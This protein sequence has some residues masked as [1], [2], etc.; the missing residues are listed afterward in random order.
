MKAVYFLIIAI[1]SASADADYV[2][3]KIEFKIK[4][5]GM[6]VDGSMD[7][8]ELQFIQPSADPSTW[9]LEGSASPAT[10]STGI[11][12]RDKHLKRADY[13]D[14]EKYPLI[15]IQSSQIRS[16]GKSKY[17]GTFAI[18]IKGVSKTIIIPFNISEN[19]KAKQ[20]AGEFTINRLDFGIG[21][22]SS[23]LA[24]AVAI[25]VTGVFSPS[26]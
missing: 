23:I 7:I 5:M 15:R 9:S 17:E 20:V 1:M 19:N 13:F 25:K 10:I 16:K 26:K 8:T 3:A 18:T 2:S 12:L 14:I 6:T 22:K 21:E 11:G 24:D 4:N